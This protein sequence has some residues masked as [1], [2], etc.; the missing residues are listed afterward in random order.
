[1]FVLAHAAD[2]V[3][4]LILGGPVLAFGVWLALAQLRERRAPRRPSGSG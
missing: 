4:S 2:W 3:E 1:V